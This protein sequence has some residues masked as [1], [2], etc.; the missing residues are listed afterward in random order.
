[1]S[2]LD[3]LTSG[4]SHTLVL[5]DVDGLKDFT[6]I[7]SFSANENADVQDHTAMDGITR[8]PKLHQGWHG[9]FVY[10]RG[11][12]VLDQYFA[13]QERVYYQGGD[14]INITITETIRELNGTITQWQYTNCVLSLTDGGQY[15]GTTIVK[16]SVAFKAR[17]K[18]PL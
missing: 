5:T 7:E 1:M 10:Q 17:R 11:S 8:H 14:Q 9:S 13:K 12:P 4:I 6:I 18:I 2:N 16:Q 3:G 15:S